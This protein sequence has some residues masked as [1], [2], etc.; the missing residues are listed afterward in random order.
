MSVKSELPRVWAGE[1]KPPVMKSLLDVVLAGDA[2]DT[3]K[4]IR[5]FLE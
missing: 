5:C 1:K 3:V 2:W 4:E